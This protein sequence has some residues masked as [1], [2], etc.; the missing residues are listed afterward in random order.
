[1]TALLKDGHWILPLLGTMIAILGTWLVRSYGALWRHG[2]EAQAAILKTF[3]PFLADVRFQDQA[4][5]IHLIEK[6]LPPRY[7]RFIEGSTRTVTYPPG[8]PAR[9]A[10]KPRSYHR[11]MTFF[12]LGIV[13]MGL[14]LLAVGVQ[15]V[16]LPG[17][18]GSFSHHRPGW[19]E[20]LPP[21]R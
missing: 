20:A 17:L 6:C 5:K 9:W 15:P 2:V 1:M 13:L 4:G 11:S 7:G 3:G 8:N 12:S 16:L 19:S 10:W 14:S 21:P 18:N